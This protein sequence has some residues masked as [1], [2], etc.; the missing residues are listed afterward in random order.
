MPGTH[1]R[2]QFILQASQW[3]KERAI[4]PTRTSDQTRCAACLHDCCLISAQA[5][6]VLMQGLFDHAGNAAPV[7]VKS[8]AQAMRDNAATNSSNNNKA[9]GAPLKASRIAAFPC[10]DSLH[11][12]HSF[13]LPACRGCST[14]RRACTTAS[15]H[16]I[17][18]RCSAGRLSGQLC[19]GTLLS[20][21]G[22]ARL[23][24]CMH[25]A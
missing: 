11:Q 17:A 13:V 22:H 6:L 25:A 15:S 7:T 20:V 8:Y 18:V 21:Q 14:S 12:V 9:N 10:C 2:L 5:T 3:R 24:A 1:P 19:V 23:H 4:C 16:T